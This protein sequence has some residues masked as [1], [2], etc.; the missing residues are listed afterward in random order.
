MALVEAHCV[1]QAPTAHTTGHAAWLQR[2]HPAH[3]FTGID[4]APAKAKWSSA[5]RSGA[6]TVH[7]DFFEDELPGAAFDGLEA[8]L[9]PTVECFASPLNCRFERY[10][11]AFPFLERPFGSLGST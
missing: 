4:R 6:C 11:S 8:Y 5:R 9:G 7:A 3:R 10:Y 1:T 2:R